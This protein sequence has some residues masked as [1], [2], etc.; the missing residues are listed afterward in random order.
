M[1]ATKVKAYCIGQNF[2]L[3]PKTCGKS[4]LFIGHFDIQR[5]YSTQ[6]TFE[7]GF[8]SDFNFNSN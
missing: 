1:N 7:M 3:R 8:K 6:I 4:V 2:V 5:P